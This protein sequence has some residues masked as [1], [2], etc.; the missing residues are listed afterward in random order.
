MNHTLFQQA[1][2]Y[3]QSQQWQQALFAYM[4]L[5]Q[6]F[7][8]EPEPFHM[9]GVLCLQMGQA[10][11]ATS[12][13]EAAI[14]INPQKA[15]YYSNL[16]AAYRALHNWDKAEA[17]WT[18]VL[19]L[20]PGSGDSYFNLG[21]LHIAKGQR[22][23]AKS[24]WL[25]A[26]EHSPNNLAALRALAMMHRE[27]DDFETAFGYADKALKLQPQSADLQDLAGKSAFDFGVILRGR[28]HWK[29]AAARFAQAT[30]LLPN[31]LAAWSMRSEAEL[32][33]GDLRAAFESC[34]AA[35]QL[36][37]EKPELHHNMGNILRMSGQEEQ[38]IEAY[39]RAIR[40]GSE[41]SATQQ[42]IAAL[43]GET[44]DTNTEVVQALFDQYADHFDSHL[45]EQL[46]YRVPQK[47]FAL[48]PD[49][50]KAERALDLG[51]GTGLVAEAFEGASS[52]WLG[53]DLSREMLG[54]TQ[55][56]SLY[57][58]LVHGEIV[59]FLD[60][61]DRDF[62]LIVC[63][64]TLIYMAQVEAFFTAVSA[65]LASGGL[66][67]FSTE[68]SE[69]K[70]IVLQKSERYALHPRYVRSCIE[71]NHLE[72][73]IEQRDQLRRDG[74]AWIEGTLW[75]CTPVEKGPD[76]D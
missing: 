54:K 36:G 4:Q 49:D 11:K 34:K 9:L 70:D 71:R 68:N 73:K 67:L 22:T 19:E 75:L 29:A 5:T 45:I 51:C 65:H 59:Q 69:D 35:I 44:V 42:A 27:D 31:S 63:A 1:V 12:Y 14:V 47:L 15:S 8:N 21:T 20:N 43:R 17:A 56:K 28:K 66:F 72:V 24:L 26:V 58:E 10:D 60:Q 2:S 6:Q 46:E 18:K 33:L 64:D 57:Q 40:L 37:P 76:S 25:K 3:H 7:P 16:G 41:S 50:F 62:D 53:V 13:I 48:L 23:E 61:E 74:T 38:A 55:E 32:K 30:E 39:E 52:F